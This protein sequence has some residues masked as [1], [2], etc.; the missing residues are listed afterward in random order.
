MWVRFTRNFDFKP[1]SQVTIAYRAGSAYNVT[2]SCADAA[3]KSGA[4]VKASKPSKT[5]AIE[6]EDGEAP[7]RR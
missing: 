6:I 1:S 7:Q 2:R 3:I 4:A 5:A